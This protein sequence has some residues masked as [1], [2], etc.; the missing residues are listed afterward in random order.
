LLI[1]D[2]PWLAVPVFAIVSGMA[3]QVA[4]DKLVNPLRGKDPGS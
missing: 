3:A 1:E 4:H 2:V